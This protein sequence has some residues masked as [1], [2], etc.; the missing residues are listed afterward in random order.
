MVV[1]VFIEIDGKGEQSVLLYPD[2]LFPISETIEGLKKKFLEWKQA[3][4]SKG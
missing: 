3:F 4:E 1:D 2:N